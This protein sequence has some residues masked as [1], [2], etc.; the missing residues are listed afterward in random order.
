MQ[1]VELR[2][3]GDLPP[4]VDEEAACSRSLLLA[5]LR[6]CWGSSLDPIFDTM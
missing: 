2:C 6:G 4:G 1:T 3:R 5:G